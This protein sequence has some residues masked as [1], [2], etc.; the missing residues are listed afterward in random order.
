MSQDI[1]NQFIDA[2]A[3]AGCAPDKPSD[4]EPT[5][6]DC[7]YRLA[8]DRKDKRGGYCLTIESD[9]FAWG[10]FRSFKT[11]EH[12]KW[13][14]GKSVKAQTKEERAAIDAR[15]K[16][17]EAVKKAAQE[18]RHT[19]AAQEAT[20]LWNASLPALDHPY[21]TNKG[22]KAHGARQDGYDLIIQGV[23][24]GKLWTYQR[25]TQD[26]DKLFLTGGK[27]QGCFFPMTA[28]SEDKGVILITEGFATAASVRE[29]TGLPT[30][31]AFDA[32]NLLPVAKDMRSKYPES[33]IIICADNDHNGEKN[34]GV[35]AAQQAAVKVGGFAV[36]P[37]FHDGSDDTDWNDYHRLHGLEAVKAKILAALT[38]SPARIGG[39]GVSP[40]PEIDSQASA[41]TLI[42][43]WQDD[44]LVPVNAPIESGKLSP[45][46]EDK[47]INNS[48]I[49]KKWPSDTDAGKLE[50]NSLH[51]IL[52]YL[53]HKDKYQGLFR[54]D[55][56]AGRVIVHREPFWHGAGRFKVRELQ[57]IDIG[58]MTASMEKDGLAPSGAKVHEAVN[59][60][61][62]ENWID[63]PLDYFN[64]IKWDG[65]S[66]LST[67]L[68]KYLGA[69]GEGDY[70]DAVGSAFCIAL[71]ARQ[72]D[73]GCKAENMLVLEG[74]QGL[75]KSTALKV[76]ADVG[77]GED[78]ESYFCDTLS[79]DQLKDKDS[80]LKMQGK[81]I[82]EIPDLAGLSGGEIEE[83]KQRMSIT[84]DEI[85]VPYGREM[86]KFPRRFVWAGSTNESHWLK[87]QTGNRRFWPVDCGKIDIKGLI[88][89]RE[90]I[91]AEAVYKYKNKAQWWIG[92]DNPI[93]GVVESEQRHRLLED[94]WFSPVERFVDG[95]NFITVGEVLQ[96]LKIDTK[97]QNSRHQKQVIGILKQL[98]YHRKE[99]RH[100]GRKVN[101]WERISSVQEILEP[102][103]EE[104]EIT[105]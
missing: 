41:S 72:Y 45:V 95:I 62:H 75:L 71:V 56:F 82:I 67:W 94:I 74:P 57:D 85:R 37:D 2:M 13:H 55:R 58:Y 11:G 60:V 104:M 80:V 79:F 65:V 77:C 89:D 21:L 12:G 25:I 49:W 28:A 53:R 1:I 18:A 103:F 91:I 31:A 83:V 9:G 20:T 40:T 93:W 90:Q 97:D 33:K 61:A 101:G 19:K 44:G 87:D 48:L 69:K 88:A 52:V 51:N 34:T 54:F 92:R 14:S 10:N 102:E 26:G 38:P 59:I 105:F 68:V 96:H 64:A 100:N 15:I 76:L 43:P 84:I 8:G 50:P 99:K 70:L 66:R 63:P 16:A 36:W 3:A 17:A 47:K 23:S 24:G 46:F 22:V 98:G 35:L 78:Q 42:P 5:G 73:P 7:Y 30:L 32:G 4:I 29:A 39:A 27:K 81:T 86:M 6:E